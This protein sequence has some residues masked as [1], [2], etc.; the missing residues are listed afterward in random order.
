MGWP[1]SFFPTVDG[2]NYPHGA[3][4]ATMDDSATGSFLSPKSGKET[5]TPSLEWRTDAEL[6]P[7]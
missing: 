7:V 1:R 6:G 3:C 5:D 2:A 4:T